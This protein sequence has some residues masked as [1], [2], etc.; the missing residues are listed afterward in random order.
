MADTIYCTY[1]KWHKGEGA[2]KFSC[3]GQTGTFRTVVAGK[4]WA[5]R[6]GKSKG[7]RVVFEGV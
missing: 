5:K 3:G 2:Y 4:A 1:Y 6:I 7:K